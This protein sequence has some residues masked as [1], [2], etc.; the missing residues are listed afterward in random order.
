MKNPRY[1][2]TRAEGAKYTA[3]TKLT[4]EEKTRLHCIAVE[5]G[6]SDYE[7]TRRII[8]EYIAKC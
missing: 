2:S 8:Q 4:E 1:S 3:C 5:R 7:L 6:L